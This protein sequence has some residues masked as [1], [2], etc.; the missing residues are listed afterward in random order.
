[1]TGAYS[2]LVISDQASLSYPVSA[3][4]SSC[5]QIIP[6]NV[7]FVQK[8]FNVVHAESANKKYYIIGRRTSSTNPMKVANMRITVIRLH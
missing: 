5:T 1:M 3:Y 4:S 8:V 6:K 2:S 7:G